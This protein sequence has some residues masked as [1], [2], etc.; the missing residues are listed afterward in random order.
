[1][2]L[3]IKLEALGDKGL[4]WVQEWPGDA[5]M[6]WMALPSGREHCFA[7]IHGSRGP[8]DAR[9]NWI[10]L[11]SGREHWFTRIQGSR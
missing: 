1:M 4:A 3:D 6:G 2:A 9:M 11:P 10:A 7:W 5:R 8:G